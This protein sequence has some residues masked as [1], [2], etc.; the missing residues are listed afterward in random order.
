MKKDTLNIEPST[1]RTAKGWKATLC[2]ENGG[3]QIFSSLYWTE[4]A[5]KRAARNALK[6]RVKYAA[7]LA[8]NDPHENQLMH[9]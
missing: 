2:F 4:E 9:V 1:K 6:M 5:A 8:H 7:Q 3:V